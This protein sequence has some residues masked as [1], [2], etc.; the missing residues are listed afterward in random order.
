VLDRPH[1][2]GVE[3][4]LEAAIAVLRAATAAAAAAGEFAA[5]ATSR[6]YDKKR[7][8]LGKRAL[9]SISRASV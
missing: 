9:P 6:P 8:S 5:P 1:R 2:G 4:Q 3:S 7:L